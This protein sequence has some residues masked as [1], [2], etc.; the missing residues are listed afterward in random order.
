MMTEERKAYAAWEL[1]DEVWQLLE[2]LLPA[3][4]WW[5]GRPTEVDLQQIAAGIF[6]VLRTGVQWQAVPREEFGPPST[7]YYYFRQWA[8]AHVFER[9]WQKALERYDA[10]AGLEWL[11]QS[12]DTAMTKAP[13]GG[14]KN[15]SQS[16][17]PR[18]GGPQAQPAGGGQGYPDRGG[19]GG[20][21]RAGHGFA[22]RDAGGRGGAP[23]G[24]QRTGT[25]AVVSGQG[26]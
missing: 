17:R 13:Q 5:M 22:G 3:R 15:R 14:E 24:A 18:Q 10:L 26:L 7:V 1:P 21:Q 11:W 4:N 16:D 8:D 6:Y 12:L 20:G 23:T 19:R 25:A 9:L 2:P